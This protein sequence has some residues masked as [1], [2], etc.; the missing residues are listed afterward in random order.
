[1]NGKQIAGSKCVE[2]L[3]ELRCVI[4][5]KKALFKYFKSTLVLNIKYTGTREDQV[6]RAKT[7]ISN[8][9]AA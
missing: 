7:Q 4:Y 8:R 1:M 5:N 2:R 3:A 9:Q 6:Y